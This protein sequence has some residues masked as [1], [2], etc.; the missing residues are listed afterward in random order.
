MQV[1][2]ENLAL[3]LEYAIQERQ[4][5]EIGRKFT[6]DSALLAGW[7]ITRKAILDGEHLE[8]YYRGIHYY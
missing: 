6:G 4:E 5:E 2:L 3:A 8:F 1:H 7:K